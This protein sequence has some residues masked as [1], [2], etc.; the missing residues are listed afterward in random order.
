MDKKHISR[1]LFHS[2]NRFKNEGIRTGL[3]RSRGI[4]VDSRNG[5]KTKRYSQINFSLKY[6]HNLRTKSNFNSDIVK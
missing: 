5:N 4:S 6:L 2:S 1:K 3:Q